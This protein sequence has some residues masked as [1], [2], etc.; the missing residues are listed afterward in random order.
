MPE[1]VQV[2]RRF[3][4]PLLTGSQAG[5]VPINATAMITEILG[6]KN[7][8]KNKQM[9]RP[10][11]CIC[12]IVVTSLSN[13]LIMYPYSWSCFFFL[14]VS[15]F[16]SCVS[17]FTFLFSCLSL[18]SLISL[19]QCECGNQQHQSGSQYLRQGEGWQLSDLTA[20]LSR[21]RAPA[22]D[23]RARATELGT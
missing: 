11:P 18:H 13:V 17:L 2:E 3:R 6:T 1:T 16:T 12:V 15:V 10:V 4:Q 19:F 23:P 14:S 7:N 8:K 5:T 9:I 21:S 22:F 20:Q